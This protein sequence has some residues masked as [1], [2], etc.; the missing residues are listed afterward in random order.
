[1]GVGKVLAQPRGGA[2]DGSMTSPQER[3]ALPLPTFLLIIK[4][5]PISGGSVGEEPPARGGDTGSIPGPEDLTC[6]EPL[7]PCTTAV[8]PGLL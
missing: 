6:V 8:E 1:M 3:Q 7:S 2:D 4:L 5:W